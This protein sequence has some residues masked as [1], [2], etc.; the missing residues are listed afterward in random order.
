[1]VEKVVAER[2][3]EVRRADTEDT[4][5]WTLTV[6]G[7]LYGWAGVHDGMTW[8]EKGFQEKITVLTIYTSCLYHLGLGTSDTLNIRISTNTYGTGVHKYTW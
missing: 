2:E 1:M 6:M 4:V 5:E 8:L 3:R 7:D